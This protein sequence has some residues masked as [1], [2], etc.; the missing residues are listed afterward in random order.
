MA[1]TSLTLPTDY[2][3]AHDDLWAVALSDNINRID[4]KYV[5]DIYT[6]Q[7]QLIRIKV[8]PE[9]NNSY[10][11]FNFGDVIANEMKFDWFDPDQNFISYELGSNG[12]IFLD[13]K[14]CVGE[15][16]E[17]TSYLS[18]DSG[19]CRAVN[20]TTSAFDRFNLKKIN[21]NDNAGKNKFLTDRERT[22]DLN[23]AEDTLNLYLGLYIVNPSSE[24]VYAVEL[25][26]Y[27]YSDTVAFTETVNLDITQT[28]VFQLD[29]SPKAIN[30]YYSTTKI[31]PNTH[32]YYTVRLKHRSNNTTY[33]TITIKNI[34]N[35]IYQ[36]MPLHFMNSY[37]VFDTAYF[38]Y[39]SRLTMDIERKGFEKR[40]YFFNS[41]DVVYKNDKNKY[42]ESK[43]NYGSKMQWNYHLTMDFP[44][45]TDYK[46]LADLIQSPQIYFQSVEKGI[47]EYY[48]VTIK[49]SNFEYSKYV[50]NRLRPFEID[51]ELNQ[52]RYGF[53]R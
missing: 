4:F 19:V 34:C 53:K 23:F 45:D 51:I 2:S 22:I 24:N 39:L 35:P 7:G 25:K 30:V 28:G 16:Y 37:G 18:L 43:I 9:P 21:P 11:Y 12:E 6:E 31:N 26:A 40:D 8:F 29:I 49:G 42:T 1:I 32:K 41:E 44:S 50:N 27:T 14:I 3:S 52:K 48:P 38:K 5:F 13:T 47:V 36:T 46:W 10:G 20:F 33:D 15:E 17:G